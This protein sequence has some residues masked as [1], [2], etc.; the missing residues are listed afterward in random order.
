MRIRFVS[1]VLSVLGFC[2]A[3]SAVSAQTGTVAGRVVMSDG[4][5]PAAGATVTLKRGD[6]SALAST[7]TNA[8]GDFR[9][10]NVPIGTYTVSVS[11]I[12]YVEVRSPEVT[13]SAGATADVN[14]TLAQRATILDVVSVTSSRGAVAEKIQDSPTPVTV[15]QNDRIS[16]RAAATVAEHIKGVPGVSISQGGIA[17]ANIVSRGFNNAFSTTMMMMQDF[18]F[19]GVPSLR[20]NVPFL[21]TGTGDD[22]DRIEVMQ[23]PASALYGPNSSSGVLHLITKSPFDYPGTTITLDGGERSLM[24]LG[25][26]HAGTFS[27]K[28]G[29]K[30]SGEYFQANDWEYNDPNET[31]LNQFYSATDPRLPASRQGQLIQRD[32]G[33][34]RMSGEARLDYRP[35]DDIEAVTTLGFSKIGKAIEITTTFGAA[36]VVDWSY[37]SFQQRIRRKRTFAQVFFNGSNSGNDN[38]T[39]DQGTYYLRSGIPVVD[40]SSVL[41]AQLQQGYDLGSTRFTGGFDYIATRPK[42]EGTIMGR[43]EEDDAINEMGA[44]IQ[45]T[46]PINDK[47]DFT[48]A[49]RGDVNSRIEGSQF[50][51]R[52]AFV[53]K[54]TPRHTARF[55]YNRAFNSPASFAFFL[56]QWSG[57]RQNLGP[58]IGT[59]TDIQIMGNMPKHGWVYDRS[60]DALVNGGLCFRSNF[61]GPAP[62]S[63]SGSTLFPGMMDALA[64]ALVG[65]IAGTFGLSPAQQAAI[66]ADLQALAP[67]EANAPAILRNLGGGNVVVPWGNVRNRAP[68]GANFSNTWEIGYK[69]LIADKLRL[70]VDYWYQIRPAEPTTQVINLADAVFLSPALGTYLGAAMGTS[71]ATNGVPAPA[72][73]TVITNWTTTLAGIPGGL[74]NYDNPAYDQNYLIFT[75][76]N[77]EG[78]VDVRGIDLG[79][80]YILTDMVT[81]EGSYSWLSRN[82]FTKA[83]GA[84]PANPLT[85]NAPK[86]RAT[87]AL[88]FNNGG[89]V[90]T[91]TGELRARY[92]D[93]MPVN[94]GVFNSYN[95]GTPVRYFDVP[96]GFFVDA[97]F[98]WRLPVAQNVRWGVNGQNLMNNPRPSFVGVPAVGRMVTTR[99]QYNF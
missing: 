63:A 31:A 94:S 68:L 91:L 15:I 43:N 75:Y 12:G 21:F 13:V 5:T 92:M 69:G 78:H 64:P 65:A 10:A 61:T 30:V 20:V 70:S 98:S 50:S 82:E 72:I 27:D 8:S 76:Q 53:Y 11:V 19:A 6:V 32:F 36:Q 1:K 62:V 88:R 67:T 47:V 83:P 29:Y 56:D 93:A 51:P 46:H 84:T 96:V 77:G 40:Q 54:I 95:I 42:T 73:P 26:R 3:A 97:G 86:N 60:C 17:Q 35:T 37:L 14:V 44:Y 39:D 58:G 16:E 25:M 59:A 18:R 74:L 2:L 66:I 52:A 57:Q 99:L 34:E 71:L 4:S 55:T 87:V 33:L 89:A 45:M 28:L 7:R 41:V 23:G 38:A 79:I 80:D 9:I 81:I 24:R 49:L 22:I 90:P 85:A 48:A